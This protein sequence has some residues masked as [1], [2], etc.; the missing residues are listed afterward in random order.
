MQRNESFK[1][2]GHRPAFPDGV[3]GAAAAAVETWEGEG[4]TAARTQPA[5][6]KNPVKKPGQ[7]VRRKGGKLA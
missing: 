2:G 3:N 5:R 1:T 7:H 4:G 6:S